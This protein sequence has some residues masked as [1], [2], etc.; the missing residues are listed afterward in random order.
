MVEWFGDQSFFLFLSLGYRKG[1]QWAQCHVQIKKNLRFLFESIICSVMWLCL[2][3][4][5]DR[6]I[7]QR[8][9]LAV[10]CWIAQ[11]L[12]QAGYLS[13]GKQQIT[14]G[15][16]NGSAGLNFSQFD[17]FQN[18]RVSPNKEVCPGQSHVAVAVQAG[19]SGP[20][21][22]PE[23]TWCC[24]SSHVESCLWYA[25]DQSHH[26]SFPAWNETLFHEF[27]CL[28]LAYHSLP[29]SHPAGLGIL[30][31]QNFHFMPFYFYSCLGE[32]VFS[33]E[34]ECSCGWDQIAADGQPA[35]DSEAK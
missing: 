18:G 3:P 20:S 17:T 34:A 13:L 29:F 4:G 1:L 6:V 16:V 31:P 8:H 2:Q 7:N 19:A 23:L 24:F 26:W 14:Y 25:T 27:K 35:A 5:V 15:Q 9:P 30:V 32:M 33:K 22:A 28:F 10:K 11:S 21:Q 12:S